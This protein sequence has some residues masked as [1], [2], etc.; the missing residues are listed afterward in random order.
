MTDQ[1]I[2]IYHSKEQVDLIRFIRKIRVNPDRIYNGSP[3]WEWQ[4][5]LDRAGYS[6]TRLAGHR[7]GHRASHEL[8]IG[9]IPDG[10]QVDHLC[11]NRGCVSPLHIESV[12]RQENM[13]RAKAFKTHCARGHEYNET[14]TLL[15][16]RRD[17]G[18]S[19]KCRACNIDNQKR[20]QAQNP[21]YTQKFIGRHKR[22]R[23]AKKRE[24][25]SQ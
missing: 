7:Q 3:C 23:E 17:G 2:S 21:G 12:T 5:S 19:R 10:Y 22:Y 25:L 11:R 9:P 1:N 4:G 18:E 15:V 14:N 20:F 13:A 6:K 8:F 16:K 24:K